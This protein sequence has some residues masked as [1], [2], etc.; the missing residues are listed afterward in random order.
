MRP[1]LGRARRALEQRGV[2]DDQASPHPVGGGWAGLG[3]S[4]SPLPAFL[5]P[6]PGSPAPGIRACPESDLPTGHPL[7]L[8]T[9]PETLALGTELEL[10]VN[11]PGRRAK[12]PSPLLLGGPWSGWGGGFG[13]CGSPR[14]A[15]GQTKRAW[16]IVTTFPSLPQ[17][18]LGFSPRAVVLGFRRSPAPTRL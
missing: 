2:R 18:S 6:R 4:W 15:R 13:R 3:A 9:T 14:G 5:P 16:I 7:S 12:V 11:S 1:R 17:P 10:G 8:G